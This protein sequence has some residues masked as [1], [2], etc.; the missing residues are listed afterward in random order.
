MVEEQNLEWSARLPRA[1][2][3]HHVTRENIGNSVQYA[4][5]LLAELAR[6]R[7]GRNTLR[8]ENGHPLG[9]T[10]NSATTHK[11]QL[12]STEVDAISPG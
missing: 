1:N 3:E 7:F 9:S 4:P 10:S 11:C 6:T 8:H 2:Q 5:R 12:E